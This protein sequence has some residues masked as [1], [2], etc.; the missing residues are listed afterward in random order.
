MGGMSAVPAYVC[1]TGPRV[2]VVDS[3]FTMEILLSCQSGALELL[4]AEGG[5][6]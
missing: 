3:T 5:C 4:E 6:R 1:R 2:L